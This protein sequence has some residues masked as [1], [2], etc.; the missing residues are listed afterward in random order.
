MGQ[1]SNVRRD[2]QGYV[3]D[4]DPGVLSQGDHALLGQILGDDS[5]EE[6]MYNGPAVPLMVFHRQHG[7]CRVSSNIDERYA[8]WF[9]QEIA[10]SNGRFLDEQHPIFDGSLAD[11]SRINVTIPPVSKHGVAIT[12]R[13]FSRIKITVADMV[14]GGGLSPE[15]AGF[16]WL[17]MD[18]FGRRSANMLVVGGTGSGKTTSLGAFTLLMPQKQRI[19]VI[20]DTPELQL[21]HPNK[22]NLVTSEAA[23]MDHLLRG[24]LRMRPDRIIVGEVRGPEAKTLFGAM[25]TGHQGCAGTLH[26]NSGRECMNRVTSDPMAVPLSQTVGLDLV[27]VQQ[28]RYVNGTPKRVVAEIAE[29]GGFGEKT[30]RI[31]QLFVWSN[32]QDQLVPT[33]IPSRLRTIICHEAGVSASDFN[34]VLQRRAALLSQL[35]ASKVDPAQFLRAVEP[36]IAMTS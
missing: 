21:T 8:L 17:C 15:A 7:M 16:L 31:N 12:I 35:A 29:L 10:K 18:G 27:V 28:R 4:V 5:L 20:E 24:A 34:A 30:A 19:V 3:Y 6:V 14:R 11:G 1:A 25:N 23:D 32:E 33:G 13:K 26:A 36:E 9:A 22:V 2:A